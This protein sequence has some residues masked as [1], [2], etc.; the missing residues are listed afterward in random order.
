MQLE[1][2][3]QSILSNFNKLNDT[4]LINK[5]K[6][7]R[8]RLVCF[9]LLALC[10]IIAMFKE[11]ISKIINTNTLYINLVVFGVAII[12]CLQLLKYLALGLSD[13]NKGDFSTAPEIEQIKELILKDYAT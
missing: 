7:A 6:L 5:K 2:L 3:A 10:A 1:W 8:K 9:I 13:I 11:P 4:R 12:S